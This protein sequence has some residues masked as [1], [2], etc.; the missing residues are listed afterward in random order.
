MVEMGLS[1]SQN[2]TKNFDFR[3]HIYF[4]FELKIQPK[5]RPLKS[6]S[7]L[8]LLLNKTKATLK[9]PIFCPN[10]DSTGP[11]KGPKFG[12]KF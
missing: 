8:E 9:G 10:D 5:V 11:L 4:A 2:L 7:M 3:G 6:N 1:A 12:T